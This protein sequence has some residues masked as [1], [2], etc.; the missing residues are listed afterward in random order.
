[1][2][3]ETVNC[4]IKIIEI[5]PSYQIDSVSLDIAEIEFSDPNHYD[6]VIREIE[7][8]WLLLDRWSEKVEWVIEELKRK[9]DL[10][11]K[12]N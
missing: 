7:D 4:L 1:M 12:N 10:I 5:T 3:K 8:Y 2:G 11:S 6:L 9:R